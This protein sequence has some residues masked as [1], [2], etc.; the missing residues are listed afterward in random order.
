MCDHI[1]CL[2]KRIAALE[3][4]NKMILD[5]IRFFRLRCN[6]R[7]TDILKTINGE[8]KMNTIDNYTDNYLH[9]FFTN[10]WLQYIQKKRW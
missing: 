1:K 9:E 8:G 6:D 2:E 10:G 5:Y 4:E 3:E 7:C